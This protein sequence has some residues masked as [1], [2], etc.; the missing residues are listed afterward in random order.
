MSTEGHAIAMSEAMPDYRKREGREAEIIA[1]LD[2]SGGVYVV[3]LEA[4]PQ[5]KAAWH[6]L[7]KSGRVRQVRATDTFITANVVVQRQRPRAINLRW[8]AMVDS[9]RRLVL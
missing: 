9:V 7:V 4:V 1:E 2:I 3:W 6:R 5:R 8:R